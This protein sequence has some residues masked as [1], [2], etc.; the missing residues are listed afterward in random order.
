MDLQPLFDLKEQYKSGL[1]ER[2]LA[3][4]TWALHLCEAQGLD[5]AP[6]RAELTRLHG[7][8]KSGRRHAGLA[9]GRGSP[10]RS[11]RPGLQGIHRGVRRPRAHRHELDVGLRRNGGGHAGHRGDGAA[12]DG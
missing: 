1:A 8:M 9:E 7:L 6:A 10:G 2:V 12:A 4:L 3:E 5:P 11:L